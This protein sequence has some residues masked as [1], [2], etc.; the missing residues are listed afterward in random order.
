MRITIL[1]IHFLTDY[2]D[3]PTHTIPHQIAQIHPIIKNARRNCSN[4]QTAVFHF[5]PPINAITKV[6]SPG[7]KIFNISKTTAT[8]I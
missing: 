5:K 7:K 1:I 6:P 4:A 2:E 3:F 8:Y